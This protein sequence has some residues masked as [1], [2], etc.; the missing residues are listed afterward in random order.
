MTS[1]MKIVI[2]TLQIIWAAPYVFRMSLPEEFD[3][4]RESFGWV[5]DIS[6]DVLLPGPCYGSYLA[7]LLIAATWPLGLL[8]AST[9]SCVAYEAAPPRQG[10]APLAPPG[11]SARR[12]ERGMVGTATS[13]PTAEPASG[14]TAATAAAPPPPIMR[15]LDAAFRGNLGEI[16]QQLS[17]DPALISAP[18]PH[19]ATALH[20]AS[21]Y[22]RADLVAELLRLGADPFAQDAAG[23]TPL[24]KAREAQRHEVEAVLLA[25]QATDGPPTTALS[26]PPS[27]PASP[28][29][30]AA[31][32]TTAAADVAGAPET[33]G[34]AEAE[35]EAATAGTV[36][37]GA[38]QVDRAAGRRR[39]PRAWRLTS[40]ASPPRGAGPRLC[41]A[42]DVNRRLPS[43]ASPRGRLGVSSNVDAATAASE[44]GGGEGSSSALTGPGKERWVSKGALRR[45]L[46]RAL[47]AALILSFLLVPSTSTRI[48]R[49]FDC[50]S[51]KVRVLR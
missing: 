42:R 12:S 40:F 39:W 10:A 25:H 18:G 35:G 26:P 44:P 21:R 30:G 8:L 34:A 27:P 50:V 37:P 15:L 7:R 41:T 1:K 36:A 45:G 2:T 28:K 31:V 33:A 43:F 51:F 13:G 16:K 6:L 24:E 19:G 3:P 47:P 20:I 32:V 23:A 46:L 14:T 29:G 17:L 38:A 49:S 22:G 11:R 9:L 48:L 5:S 4:L